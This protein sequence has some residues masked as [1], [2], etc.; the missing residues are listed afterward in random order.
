MI[1]HL[2]QHWEKLAAYLG[3][4]ELEIDFIA[5]TG[6]SNVYREIQMFMRTW[7]MPDCGKEKTQAILSQGV[8]SN[9]ASLSC[10]TVSLALDYSYT[11]VFTFVLSSCIYCV[12]HL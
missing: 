8:C 3:Y 11:C 5:R 10:V 12:Y 4:T 9:F 6:G 7:W 1:H 2:K